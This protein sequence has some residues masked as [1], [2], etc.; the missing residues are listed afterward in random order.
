MKFPLYNILLLFPAFFTCISCTHPAPSSLELS[1]SPK[2]E[3]FTKKPGPYKK[4]AEDPVIFR[5]KD[6]N[7][8][9]LR[10][11]TVIILSYYF[12]NR[13]KTGISIEKITGS[14]G[15]LTFD[16]PKTE[17]LPNEESSILVKFA[18]GSIEGFF[19][20]QIYVYLKNGKLITLSFDVSVI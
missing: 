11:D 15:C 10:K 13:G 18:P 3:Y 19:K 9:S 8:G 6:L 16:Y 4:Q 7:I 14:C 20:K 17:I 12:R 1:I 2:V 5:S